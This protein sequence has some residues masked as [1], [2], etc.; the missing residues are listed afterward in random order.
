MV[1]ELA[2]LV[3][4]QVSVILASGPKGLVKI[5]GVVKDANDDAGMITLEIS[6]GG[7]FM[8]KGKTKQMVFFAYSLLGIE[9]EGGVPV[10]ESK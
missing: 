1:Q 7:G 4:K 8:S 10:P 9:I 2:D 5:K 6:A 3:G